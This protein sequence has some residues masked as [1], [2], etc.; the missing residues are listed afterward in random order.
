MSSR[1]AVLERSTIGLNI[2]HATPSVKSDR[3]PFRGAQGVSFPRMSEGTARSRRLGHE[4]GRHSRAELIEE[5]QGSGSRCVHLWAVR[6][7]GD[8]GPT[9]LP[10]VIAVV[11]AIRLASRVPRRDRTRRRPTAVWAP[12]SRALRHR[13]DD[14]IDGFGVLQPAAVGASPSRFPCRSR[15]RNHDQASTRSNASRPEQRPTDPRAVDASYS[16]VGK[17]DPLELAVGGR[18][19][20]ALRRSTVSIRSRAN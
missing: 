4:H 17:S 20:S 18:A 15:C 3:P 16:T 5:S 13:G 19:A 10:A 2:C 14:L 1:T 7:G 8:R 9:P 6:R 12:A 11:L